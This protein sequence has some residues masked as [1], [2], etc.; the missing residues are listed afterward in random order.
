VSY[1]SETRVGVDAEAPLDLL[2]GFSFEII[3]PTDAET[4][5]T[6]LYNAH[7]NHATVISLHE[8]KRLVKST[9]FRPLPALGKMTQIC[10][11]S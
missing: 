11:V 7:T 6:N 9:I 10:A 5:G 4:T 2:V 8:P 3:S 1:L